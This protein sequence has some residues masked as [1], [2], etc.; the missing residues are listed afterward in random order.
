MTLSPTERAEVVQ[1]VI[2]GLLADLRTQGVDRF[3]VFPLA[4]VAQLTGLSRPTIK[5]RLP[6]VE[7]TPGKTGVR[8]S[9][10]DAYLTDSTR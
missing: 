3:T 6:V 2:D 9:D 4:T 5:K 7:L 10:L 1:G 8:A